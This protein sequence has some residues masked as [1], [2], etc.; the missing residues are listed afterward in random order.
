MAQ[1]TS[2]N[3]SFGREITSFSFIEAHFPENIFIDLFSCLLLRAAVV[4]DFVLKLRLL[5]RSP[6]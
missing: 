3:I 1:N 6:Q 5:L 4:S 2:L